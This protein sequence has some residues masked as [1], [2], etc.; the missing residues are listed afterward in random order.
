[1]PAPDRKRRLTA[2]MVAL[3]VLI[4]TP[5]AVV[6]AD[7]F[8]DV[9]DS[10]V[11][12]DDIAW[13]ADANVTKGCNPPDNTEFCPGD[14]V[15]REQMAAFMRRLAQNKVVD[16]ATAETADHATTAG[17]A[18]TVYQAIRDEAVAVTGA[19]G[20]PVSVATLDLEPGAYMISANLAATALI[21]GPAVPQSLVI[22]ELTA[23]EESRELSAQIGVLEG[24]A[25]Y[26]SMTI[27]LAVTVGT[28]SEANVSCWRP[29]GIG[30][31]RPNI[32][33]GTRLMAFSLADVVTT[34][35][36]E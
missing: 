2:F 15:T 10:N 13:L 17:H 23:G 5:L 32:R 34:T 29:S 26:Q 27:E 24:N 25:M 22:C 28:N 21:G 31:E 35:V 8:T 11:F 19:A 33:P 1:M 30:D 36:T 7:A 6:A 9:P 14:N 12:H 18:G 20:A 3:A 4:A 16:A